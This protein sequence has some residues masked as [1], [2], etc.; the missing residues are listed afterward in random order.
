VVA[1]TDNKVNRANR[2][3]SS[4]RISAKALNRNRGRA[5]TRERP[6]SRIVKNDQRVGLVSYLFMRAQVGPRC[7]IIFPSL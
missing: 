6:A 2:V 7:R 3:A 5:E 1:S 4:S